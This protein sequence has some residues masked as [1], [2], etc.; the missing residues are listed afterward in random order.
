VNSI[1][2]ESGCEDDFVKERRENKEMIALKARVNN[3]SEKSNEVSL[4]EL[5]GETLR[6]IPGKVVRVEEVQDS[7]IIYINAE[8]EDLT[9]SFEGDLNTGEH[10][11]VDVEPGNEVLFNARFDAVQRKWNAIK[12]ISVSA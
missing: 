8:V 9:V 2:E 12:I 11:A 4:F 1:L 6:E 5:K 10:A 7:T 3:T